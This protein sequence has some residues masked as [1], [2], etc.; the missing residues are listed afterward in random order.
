MTAD[1]ATGFH[2]RFRRVLEYIDAHLDEALPLE[3]LS[4]VAAFSKF[5]FQRQFTELFQIGVAQYVQLL[6]LHRA[7]YK[8]AYRAHLSITTIAHDSGYD[9]A[10]AFARAF[11]K[12]LGQSPSEFRE[13]PNL[14][15]WH[16]LQHQLSELRNRHMS[17]SHTSEAVRIEEFNP[18]RVA[19]YEHRG[20]PKRIGES[21]QRFIE[22]RKQNRL[23]PRISATF[24]IAY[25]DPDLTDPAEFRFDLCAA[26]EQSIEPNSYGVISKLIPGGR[27]AVLRHTGSDSTLAQTIHYLFG[28]WLPASAEEPRDFPLFMRRVAFFPDVPEHE[29]ITDVYLPLK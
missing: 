3:R 2:A 14:E 20:D 18:T 15:T 12:K 16:A 5:H 8:L 27:C 22:W 13:R 10:E 19:V 9:G 21:I 7:G 1:T 6:R 24:N 4:D 29:A 25:D 17:P 11:R 28:I 26:T 23:P